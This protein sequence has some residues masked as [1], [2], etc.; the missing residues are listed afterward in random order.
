MGTS[1]PGPRLMVSL[2]LLLLSIEKLVEAEKQVG[3]TVVHSCWGMRK[4]LPFS[5]S[6]CKPVV[7][8]ACDT[9]QM[10]ADSLKFLKKN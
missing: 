6:L 4:L 8:K 9:R 2:L 10:C 1:T 3:G 7:K 5:E